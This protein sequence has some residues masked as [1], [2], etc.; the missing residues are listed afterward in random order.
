[1]A[2]LAAALAVITAAPALADMAG[3]RAKVW[4]HDYRPIAPPRVIAAAALI[5]V[6]RP[7][8]EGNPF[9]DADAE[10]MAQAI[11]REI[12]ALFMRAGTAPAGDERVVV[13]VRDLRWMPGG[14]FSRVMQPTVTLHDPAS[15]RELFRASRRSASGM[16]AYYIDVAE[17]FGLLKADVVQAFERPEIAALLAPA[18]APVVAAVRA[19]PAAQ[20]ESPVV[21]LAG[22]F[23]GDRPGG[24]AWLR[25]DRAGDDYA[26]AFVKSTTRHPLK[27]AAA[28]E[29][30]L[31]ADEL[32]RFPGTTILGGLVDEQDTIFAVLSAELAWKGLR[33]RFVLLDFDFGLNPLFKVPCP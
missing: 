11:E 31:M 16:R 3:E 23:A 24:P 17:V 28:D 26:F 1:M 9:W 8:P 18:A 33:T 32:S 19:A 6:E 22:C 15:G 30:K 7:P 14:G 12:A 4:Q 21:A 20:A 2:T 5:Q 10:P 29:V 25:I 13:R 27:P